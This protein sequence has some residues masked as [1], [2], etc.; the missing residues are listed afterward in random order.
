MRS[1]VAQVKD[2]E[3]FYSLLAPFVARIV[4]ASGTACG[5]CDKKHCA[6]LSRQA[7]GGGP[8]RNKFCTMFKTC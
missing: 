6:S 5:A 2:N 4:N 7:A 8:A 3:S 1:R